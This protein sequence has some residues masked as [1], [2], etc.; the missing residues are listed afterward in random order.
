MNGF[1]WPMARYTWR[2]FAEYAI[3]AILLYLIACG[4]GL[5]FGRRTRQAAAIRFAI[6][7]VGAVVILLVKPPILA[8]PHEG[9]TAEFQVYSRAFGNGLLLL[10]FLWGITAIGIPIAT[11]WQRKQ[12]RIVEQGNSGDTPKGAPDS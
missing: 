7:T 4:I 12:K 2:G 6:V 3:P 10:F 1:D 11:L 8:I 9:R 5:A